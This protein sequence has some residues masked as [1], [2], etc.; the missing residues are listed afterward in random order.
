M[1]EW[2]MLTKV[3]HRLMSCQILCCIITLIVFYM[4]WYLN[5]FS[6]FLNA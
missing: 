1:S 2:A 3:L 6:K 4:S 5:L